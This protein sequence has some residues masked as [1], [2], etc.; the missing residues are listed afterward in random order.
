MGKIEI[1]GLGAGDWNQ[2][3]VG[4]FKQLQEHTNI[5]LRTKEHPVVEELE[6]NGIHYRDFDNLYER[7]SSFE[8]VYQ[9]IAKE[10]LA[11]AKEK[12]V[13]YAVPGH[14]M[15]AE[16]SV[17]QLLHNTEE[18]SVE[19]LGG[20]SFL[21]DFFQAV[22]VDP[23]EGFQ[24]VDGLRMDSDYLNLNNHLI[25]M[26]VY[27]DLVAGDV[28]L[29]LMEKY[30]DEHRV[31]LVDAA[32]TSQ[33]RVEW[34]PL[35]EMDRIEGV[36]NLL[37][38]YVPPLVRDEQTKS[39]ATTQAYMDAIHAGDIWVQA[40][41]HKTLLPYLIEETDEV[42]QAIKEEDVDNLVEELGDVLLQ[43]FYHAGYGE[44]QG[45]FS[46]EDILEN[47]NRKLRRRHPHVFDNYPVDS[48]EDIDEMWQMIK[49]KEK[50]MNNEKENEDEIR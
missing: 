29:E 23:I 12:D 11:Q 48:M 49:A 35:Y 6:K 15:V 3:P 32:G 31:A 46:M 21:D 26:Q 2:L 39:F 30:P 4:V 27:N 34:M 16:D 13:L 38:V 33:E 50:E 1:V 44:N 5:F 20:K 9:E 7:E 8:N 43:I 28:K 17:K 14:P 40:Q 42:A 24:L 10:L 45:T 37:S 22:D 41:N 47:L 36:H 18:I 19:I 25:V